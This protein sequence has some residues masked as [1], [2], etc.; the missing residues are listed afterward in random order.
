VAVLRLPDLGEIR[1]ELLPELAPRTV[2]H[3][4]ELARRGDF[5]GTYFH[6]VLPGFMIQGG[7]PNTRDND[8]RNDGGGGERGAPDEISGYPYLRGTVAMANRGRPDTADCQ[9]FIVHQDQA[10]LPPD[11]TVFGRV[12]EGMEV[13]DAITRLE[14]D[15]YGRYGPR[16]R[17]YPVPA[18]VESIRIESAGPA[19]A[20]AGR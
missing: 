14:I 17:P 9:F 13:V 8:P 5:D 20:V 18:S 7:D 2:A 4:A 16:N 15:K 12:I 3:F 19:P 6:R 11:Y 10:D 1:I